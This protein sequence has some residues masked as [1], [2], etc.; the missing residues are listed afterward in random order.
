MA[1]YKKRKIDLEERLVNYKDF[2]L[3]VTCI[4][5][6]LVLI[7]VVLTV[8]FFI[9]LMQQSN[10]NIPTDIIEF[11]FDSEVSDFLV[12]PLVTCAVYLIFIFFINRGVNLIIDSII[13]MHE[14][15]NNIDFS[16]DL[17]TTKEEKKRAILEEERRL[18]EEIKRIRLADERK[19]MAEQARKRKKQ[20]IDDYQV[21][22]TSTTRAQ[23]EL[24]LAKLA[25]EAEQRRQEKKAKKE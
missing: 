24:D 12:V 10:I 19:K 11:L 2:N 13:S 7:K 8:A 25:W 20:S 14:K 18:D 22:E 21:D 3:G 6:S 4:L 15:L 16:V 9:N 5:V 23:R 17:R 1:K